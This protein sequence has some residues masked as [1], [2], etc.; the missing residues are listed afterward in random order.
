[1][2]H[3]TI[4][5][6]NVDNGH[7]IECVSCMDDEVPS[8]EAA[9]VISQIIYILFQ[10][11]AY[12]NLSIV[13]LWTLVLQRVFKAAVSSFHDGPSTHATEMLHLG[14]HPSET[15]SEPTVA[16]REENVEQKIPGVYDSEPTI[17]P[18]GRLW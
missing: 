12:W 13:G 17:L 3:P 8:K 9:K 5:N 1:M 4:T 10:M 15:C 16:S 7:R 6:P 2:S 18:D 14:S 11:F